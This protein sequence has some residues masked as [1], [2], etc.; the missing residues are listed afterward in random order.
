MENRIAN[1]DRLTG[2]S[3][4]SCRSL[5]KD[6]LE[7][8]SRNK[9][10]ILERRINE[11]RGLLAGTGNVPFSAEPSTSDVAKSTK[12]KPSTSNIPNNTGVKLPYIKKNVA[13]K[14]TK[15]V[16]IKERCPAK[17]A[18]KNVTQP[19]TNDKEHAGSND[20][21]T[22]TT[23][24]ET[25]ESPSSEETD[26]AVQS[27]RPTSP[28]A[29]PSGVNQRKDPGQEKWNP[30][31]QLDITRRE[32]LKEVDEQSKRM[33]ILPPAVR[34]LF[35][36]S[37]NQPVPESSVHVYKIVDAEDGNLYL[38]ERLPLSDVEDAQDVA[39]AS[40]HRP[41]V[42]I[43]AEQQIIADREH[44]L[45]K[46][47]ADAFADAASKVGPRQIAERTMCIL[48]YLKRKRGIVEIKNIGTKCLAHA[49]LSGLCLIRITPNVELYQNDV[50]RMNQEVE[51]LCE[52][53][54]CDLPNGGSV[55]EWETLN[56]LKPFHL[57]HCHF[58]KFQ[59]TLNLPPAIKIGF[60]PHFFNIS[61][62]QNYIGTIPEMLF[63][64]PDDMSSIMRAEFLTW[65]AEQQDKAF[66][67]AKDLE[68]YC[69]SYSMLLMQACEKFRATML[70]IGN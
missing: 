13:E 44:I 35:I 17:I 50:M 12:P 46:A 33:K 58:K 69:T 52:L 36:N 9:I 68:E 20:S 28:T 64:S 27:I 2:V 1:D 25:I 59:A 39:T 3:T 56:S 38:P 4:S 8:E 11:N 43:L 62:N 29:G 47:L 26:M 31:E 19:T 54:D 16:V 41:I 48:E 10:T 37:K 67:F 18:K 70:K 65:Y 57:F 45:H 40:P 63:F 53:S 66:D 21:W 49:I 6:S 5:I 15:D 60:F 14:K 7:I 34:V 30:S 24:R 22:T 55:E 32:F 42:E 61:D 51:E 23:T